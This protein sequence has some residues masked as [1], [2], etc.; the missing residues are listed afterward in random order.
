MTEKF[1]HDSKLP[2]TANKARFQQNDYSKET[3]N[4][5]TYGGD[6]DNEDFDRY[7]DAHRQHSNERDRYG[8]S[9]SRSRS[10]SR[11]RKSPAHSIGSDFD[12]KSEE[13]VPEQIDFFG[14]APVEK[15]KAKP[16]AGAFDFD[17]GGPPAQS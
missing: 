8:R 13:P 16:E 9:R 15:P 11:G 3:R 6:S 17:F 2:P 14:M 5:D 12:K 1:R 7:K 10:G 4:Y